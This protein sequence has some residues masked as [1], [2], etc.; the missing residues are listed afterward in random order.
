MQNKEN[1]DRSC[2][3]ILNP[4][5]CKHGISKP[6]QKFTFLFTMNPLLSPL[7]GLPGIFFQ[8]LFGVGGGLKERG[9]YLI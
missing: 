6:V 4:E 7:G 2:M 9:A 8:A 5:I 1:A 3:K